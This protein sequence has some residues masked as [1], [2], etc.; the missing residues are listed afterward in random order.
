MNFVGRNKE[1]KI[2]EDFVFKAKTPILL[3]Y[4]MRGIGKTALLYYFIEKNKN[5][6]N[7]NYAYFYGF[8]FNSNLSNLITTDKNLIII[9]DFE[10]SPSDSSIVLKELV[11]KN[12]KKR[13]ILSTSQAPLIKE[14]GI[15]GRT[16]HLELAGLQSVDLDKMIKERLANI[17]EIDNSIK[18]RL[19]DYFNYNPRLLL[20][21]L[22]YLVH[23]RN[24]S[25]NELIGLIETPLRQSGLV[26]LNGNPLSKDSENIKQIEN[27]IIVV[28]DS[29]IDKAY[30]D[31]DFFYKIKPYQ[32]EELVAELL[33]KEGFKVN[34][35]KK[36]H[37]GG[38][39]I[40][41]AQNNTLGN[42]L[43]YIECKQFAPTNHVGVKFVRELYGTISADR[44]TAGLLVTTSYFSKEAKDFVE[45]VQNQLSLKG[46]LELKKWI[47]DI[48]LKTN[49]GA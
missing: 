26:D 36:T 8:D 49:N 10:T 23:N 20:T 25:I 1:L 28:N 43:Y 21:S 24:I 2:L 34:L 30:S 48:Y 35:T 45:N 19:L 29:L 33:E 42:F 5:R 4:G 32:F 12:P 31:P 6:L 41:I 40:F 17:D 27:K 11:D 15:A 47:K 16:Q 44:A 22:N 18:Q 13:I 39:D 9:D 14:T 3:L 7:D 37:D 46:Y 38:K